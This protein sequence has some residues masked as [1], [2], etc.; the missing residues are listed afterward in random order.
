MFGLSAAHRTLPLGTLL[1]V[2]SEATGKEIRVKV[3]DRGPFV[4]GR[5]VDLSYGAAKEIG[6][7]RTGTGVVHLE[8]IGFEPLGRGSG[9][10][11]IFTLQL[12]AF[13]VRENA[14]R[15]R[16]RIRERYSASVEV[17]AHETNSRVFY[18]VRMGRFPDEETARKMARTLL[19]SEGLS[20]IITRMD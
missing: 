15:L 18:R 9:R 8:V 7:I 16:D 12:G 14:K 19:K 20:P 10:R 11:A 4:S 1:L 17:L 3:N 2:R 6:L 13:V 5:I